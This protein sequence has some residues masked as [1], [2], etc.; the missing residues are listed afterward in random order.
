M[1]EKYA[2]FNKKNASQ[3]KDTILVFPGITKAFLSKDD[4]KNYMNTKLASDE[5]N[6]FKVI[7]KVKVGG[8]YQVPMDVKKF[9]GDDS[10]LKDVALCS[11]IF[12][13]LTAQVRSYKADDPA[14]GSSSSKEVR[15]YIKKKDNDPTK[16]KAT[17]I[18]VF[19]L[20]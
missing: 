6:L 9:I 7:F 4:A 5:K 1:E 17:L 15:N 14:G 16:L 10:E 20:Q 2:K 19:E 12:S 8:E 13:R 3:G 11:A 18:H